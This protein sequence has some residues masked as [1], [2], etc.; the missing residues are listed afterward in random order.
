MAVIATAVLFFT[1]LA[2][3]T[4]RACDCVPLSSSEGLQNADVVFEGELIGVSRLPLTSHFSLAY[5]FEVHKSLKG[6]AGTVVSI[7][8]DGTGCD[9]HFETDFVYRVYAKDVDG[10]LTSGKCAGNELL[11]AGPRIVSR[12]KSVSHIGPSYWQRRL[13]SI[14]EICGLGVLWGSGVFVWRRY[15]TR[16]T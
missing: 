2:C 1:L 12:S 8:G 7:F 14:V 16:P 15:L 3:D 5:T 9:A 11:D 10:A 4:A 13:I 6:S